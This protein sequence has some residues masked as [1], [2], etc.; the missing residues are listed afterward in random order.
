MLQIDTQKHLSEKCSLYVSLYF[1]PT[2]SSFY[3]EDEAESSI[4][5]LLNE[6]NTD[7]IHNVDLL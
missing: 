2:G 5:S 6:I 1:P 3:E 7:S 4:H